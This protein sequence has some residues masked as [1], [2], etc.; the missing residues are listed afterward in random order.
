MRYIAR[1]I[2]ASVQ[3]PRRRLT[4]HDVWHDRAFR[5]VPMRSQLLTAAVVLSAALNSAHAG[6]CDAVY[7]AGV[8]SVQTPH[9]V[10]STMT[11]AGKVTPSES[12]FVGGVEYIQRDGHWQR[13]T[14]SAEQ[15]LS[16]A[17]EKAASQ[18]STCTQSPDDVIRGETVEV[19]A[20]HNSET[21]ADSTVRLF[22]ALLQGQT[23]KIPNGTA[24]ETR[25]EYRNVA[26]P[27][28]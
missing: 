3:D 26:A 15:M 27:R 16:D 18:T 24:I 12:I 17:K 14:V 20:V 7:Q 21:D 9:H 23:G 5:E 10:F 13:S 28:L 19:F 11:R 8:K 1:L 4:D 22:K 25:Y 6:S 2:R